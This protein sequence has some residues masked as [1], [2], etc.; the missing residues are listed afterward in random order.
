MT[1]ARISFES[2]QQINKN[3][4]KKIENTLSDIVEFSEMYRDNDGHISTLSSWSQTID[5]NDKDLLPDE[6]GKIQKK[7]VF[8]SEYVQLNSTKEYMCDLDTFLSLHPNLK[9][10][11]RGLPKTPEA[12]YQN[13]IQQILAIQ[14]KFESALKGF[15]KQIEFNQKCDVHIG[16][17]G[18]LNINQVGYATDY[19]TEAL[20]DILNKGWRLLAVCVQ[21]DG[22]RP[23][24]VFGRYDPNS[25]DIE[26]VH[27]N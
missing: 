14:E 17:L 15:D 7:L 1:F 12:N 3:E 24:Y 11:I 2:S 6:K 27:F 9:I 10:K 19:C 25:E 8:Q 21:P 23:D 16:N 13:V 22:R 18:L 20:Q 4:L 5:P 26:C